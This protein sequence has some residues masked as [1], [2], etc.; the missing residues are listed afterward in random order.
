MLC[1]G[2]RDP[3]AIQIRDE[4][5]AVEQKVFARRGHGVFHKASP[6]VFELN[7]DT[8]ARHAF[9]TTYIHGF[10]R[11]MSEVAY[12]YREA[13]PCDHVSASV[14]AVSLAFMAAQTGSLQLSRFANASYVAA[15][16]RL[17][18][19]LQD[20]DADLAEEALQSVL[21]LDM[22][23]KLVHRN[24]QSS[25]SWLSHARGGL[26]LLGAREGSIVSST[27]GCQVAA[28]LVTAVTV[29]CATVGGRVPPEL[30]KVRR[31]I[32]YRVKSIKWSFLGLLG[33]VVN[34]KAGV[35]RGEISTY[36]LLVKAKHLDE[37]FEY[38]NRARP[39]DWQPKTIYTGTD[40]RVLGNSY[41]VHQEHYI[42]QVSNAIHTLRLILYNIVRSNIP[43]QLRSKEN[44]FSKKVRESVNP[45]CASVPQFILPGVHFTNSIPFSPVQQLHCSTLLAPMYLVNQVSEDLL[46]KEWVR[47]CF[48]FMWESGGL[49]AAKD[50]MDA[51][52]RR[53]DLDYWTV[54]AMTGSYAIAA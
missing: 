18:H 34:L 36:L 28:R 14:E 1:H 22:Y 20:L 46:V 37:Q 51:M 27:T 7:W 12:Y 5:R 24:P 42:T 9:F 43:D 8:R 32:G 53:S 47:R 3:S 15:I 6:T 11:S 39:S 54:Y 31:N 30:A 35:N 45:I 16:Q 29:S 44:D 49:K 40:A 52:D 25:H 50:I 4:S 38:L 33:Q 10:T 48:K 17:G 26:S 23:E 21:L 19:T 13:K 2:Y 41:D